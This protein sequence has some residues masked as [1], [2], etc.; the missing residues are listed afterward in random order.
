M[1]SSSGDIVTGWLVAA[2]AGDDDPV[3]SRV[4]VSVTSPVETVTDDLSRRRRDGGDPAQVRPGCF[5]SET[6]RVISGADEETG[7]GIGTEPV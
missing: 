4:G 5:G 1:G 3:E 7:G 2:H 6:L